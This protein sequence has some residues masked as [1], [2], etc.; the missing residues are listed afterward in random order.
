MDDTERAKPAQVAEPDAGLVV[1]AGMPEVPKELRANV[2]VGKLD[3][4]IGW[5]K[6]N[7]MWPLGFGLACC[8]IEFISMAASRFDIERFGAGVVRPSPRQ[9]DVI[10]VAGTLTKKMAPMFVRLYEQMAEPKYVISMGN[11]TVSG[12]IYTG[13]YGAVHGIDQLVP[14]DVYVPGCPPRP[15]ALIYALLQLQ[16]KI[17]KE[18]TFGA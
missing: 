18:R 12:G 14:V 4:L 8:F 15:D 6:A 13:S 7:S 10:V 3:E 1:S 16:K 5:G 9:A 11:C 2:L 17:A